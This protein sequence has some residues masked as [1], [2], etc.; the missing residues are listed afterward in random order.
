MRLIWKT[1][2]RS[3][4]SC[5]F[6]I[7]HFLKLPSKQYV[8]LSVRYYV[9]HPTDFCIQLH[10]QKRIGAR[11]QLQGYPFLSL[12]QIKLYVWLE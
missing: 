11:G 12:G 3:F 8:S 5:F 1:V 4:G 6:S 9:V 7:L 2:V 10:F